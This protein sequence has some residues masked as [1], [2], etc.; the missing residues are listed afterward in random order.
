[1]KNICFYA[2]I[3]LLSMQAHAQNNTKKSQAYER[4]PFDS[5]TESLPANFLGNDCRAIVRSL[6]KFDFKKDEFESSSNYRNRMESVSSSQ[7]A[8]DLKVDS[9]FI[10]HRKGNLSPK[11]S[12]DAD[13]EKLSVDVGIRQSSAFAGAEKLKIY[14]WESVEV[15]EAKPR[16]YNAS[17]AFGASVKVEER[18]FNTCAL[19]FSNEGYGSTRSIW[20]ESET[21]TPDVARRIKE[22]ATVF[23]AGKLAAPYVGYIHEP[24]PATLSS[25]VDVK[26][27]GDA[28]VF[29]LQEVIIADARTGEIFLR[30]HI[31]E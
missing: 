14:N 12:Y 8:G 1:M 6:K 20:L 15:S 22:K 21:V 27:E 29:Q 19:A 26:W 30:K 13:K 16:F 7:L 23:Y 2:A 9:T 31:A 25:P 3:L 18:R 11:I 17:N 5:T 10:F 24:S 28:L 4:R